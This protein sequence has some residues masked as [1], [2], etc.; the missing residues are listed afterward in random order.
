VYQNFESLK[1][2]F[3]GMIQFFSIQYVLDK[4]NKYFMK[5]I[6]MFIPL[7]FIGSFLVSQNIYTYAGTGVAGYTADGG[8]ATNAQIQNGDGIAV[9]ASGNV[10]F[11]DSFN[12]RIRKINSAGIISTL[13]GTGIQGYSGDGGPAINAD[14]G[15]TCGLSVDTWGNVYFCDLDNYRVRK[16][17]ASGI[18]TTIAGTGTLASSGDGGLAVNASLAF[19][20]GV[21]AD[22]SGNIYITE[23]YGARVR[24]VNS[25]GI[26]STFAG[27]GVVGFSGDGGQAI[28][29]QFD[30]PSGICTDPSGNVY[31]S[32]MFNH[33]IR[34]VNNS[35]IIST[36][37]GTGT[38][39]FSGDG[40]N[41]IN[42]EFMFPWGMAFDSFGNMYIG[43]INNYRIRKIDQS[44]IVSTIAGTGFAGATG[45]FGPALLAEVNPMR[46]IAVDPSGNIFFNETEYRVRMICYNN[47]ISGFEEVPENINNVTI[48]PNPF[49]NKI[50]ITSN[51]LKQAIQ[52][53]NSF[54]DIIYTGYS[55]KEITEIDLHNEALGIYVVRI[56]QTSRKIIKH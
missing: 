25:A 43:D 29:A 16:V 13:T 19:P 55:E 50:T 6:A 37:A 48:Y 27:T 54:G 14:I 39:G 41:A 12:F 40:G 35:G 15:N 1:N 34:K 42:A 51:E 20:R 11:I 33:G 49:N 21:A 9:D 45:D 4:T 3:R 28:N 44:G 31:I 36:Y 52:I 8:L 24:K 22:G 46:G 10:Y 17:D 26:I 23:S 2:S 53:I 30:S 47:C 38:A 18:I 56:G 7:F 5:K 32:D